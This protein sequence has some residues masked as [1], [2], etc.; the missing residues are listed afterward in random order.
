MIDRAPL[1]YFTCTLGEA[2]EANNSRSSD[3]VRTVNELLESQARKHPGL[4]AAGFPV[5]SAEGHDW[6]REIFTFQDLLRGSLEVASHLG[7]AHEDETWARTGDGECVALLCHSSIDFLFA[8]LGL[9]RAGFPV[10]LIAP[11]CSPEAIGALCKSCKVSRL[12]H[13]TVHSKAASA[14]AKLGSA[15]RPILLYWQEGTQPES[16]IC[17]LVRDTRVRVRADQVLGPKPSAEDVAYIHHSS[18]TSTGLPKPIPQSNSGAVGVLPSLEGQDAATFTTTPLYHGGIADC[19]RAWKSNA[20]IWLFPGADVPIT[21]KTILSCLS[22]AARATAVDSSPSVKYF[23]SVPYVLKMLAESPAGLSALQSMEIVG[24][25]GAALPREVGD[26]LVA[27]G[28]HLTSRFGSAECGFLLSSH[29]AYSSDTEWQYLRAPPRSPLRF[30][31]QGDGSGLSELVVLPSW[32]HMAKRNRGDG[33]YATSDL[34]EPHQ[35]IADAW[36]YHSRSDSQITLLTG[37]K[38]DPAPLEDAI[39][40]TSAVVRDVLIFGNDRQMPGVLIFPRSENDGLTAD[41]LADEIWRS[42]EKVNSDGPSHSRIARDMVVVMA[43]THQPLERSS[44]GTLLRNQAEKTY[45]MDIENA[46]RVD[47]HEVVSKE[48]Q[49]DGS[50]ESASAES[51]VRGGILEV[52]GSQVSIADEADFYQHGVDSTRATQIRSLLQKRVGRSLPWNVVYDCGNIVKLIEYI[53]KIQNGWDPVDD[54]QE[55]EMVKALVEKYSRFQVQSPVKPPTRRG[56]CNKRV[57]ILTGSTGSLGCHILEILR[58]SPDISRIICLVRA[59]D[60]ASAAKRVSSSLVQRRKLPLSPEDLEYRVWCVPFQLQQPDLGLAAKT[61][62]QIRNTV[63]HFIHAAWAVNFSL[64]L[65]SFVGEHI[66]GLHTLLNLAASCANLRRFAFCSSTASV[67]GQA[68]AQDLQQLR[69]SSI[70][71]EICTTPPPTAAL[72]YSKSKWVAEAICAQYAARSRTTSTPQP[73]LPGKIQVLRVGQLTGDTAH[74]VWNRAEAWPR[75]LAAAAQMGCLF[76]MLDD[77]E[78]DWLPVD[79]AARAVVEIALHH[80]ADGDDDS[81]SEDDSRN[82]IVYHLLNPSTPPSTWTDLLAWLRETVP[83][84]FH[85]VSATDWLDALEKMDAS[86]TPAQSLLGL[87]RAAYGGSGSGSPAAR[88]PVRFETGRAR[89]ES[90]ALREVG[91]VDGVLVGKIW[92]WLVEI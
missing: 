43:G 92:R 38:F 77:A 42:I 17:D 5:P 58:N 40:A 90:A 33:S 44:K 3:N 13:D 66:R 47:G 91:P 84:P 37:K 14:A 88:E 89:A 11:Q 48:A 22:I 56:V 61:T 75:M 35:T 79:V 51:I 34:F 12:Y 9:M 4:P 65:K 7:P 50:D 26:T 28:I 27:K 49:H 69:S 18:G 8:W 64:P 87:W 70:P 10:L 41:E 36:R 29:R 74:G 53:Q 72:G 57:V 6:G 15:L 52:M 71:E 67:L 80:D 81:N 54:G 30:E 62:E 1:N 19:F 25:G 83:P 78:L 32:Q 82:G 59:E 16:R 60:D 73:L 63:S 23:S 21:S 24:V 39:R 46:Y 2:A 85:V 76:P 55:A 86:T 45:A 68:T 31:D 20:L